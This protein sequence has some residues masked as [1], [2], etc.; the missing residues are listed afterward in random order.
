MGQGMTSATTKL[1]HRSATTTV[2]TVATRRIATTERNPHIIALT[3]IASARS[4]KGPRDARPRAL[5]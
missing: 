3:K 2:E 1:T 5:N 4:P